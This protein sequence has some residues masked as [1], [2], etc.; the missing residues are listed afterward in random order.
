MNG[1][2]GAGTGGNNVNGSAKINAGPDELPPP[3]P[4]LTGVILESK[5]NS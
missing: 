4:S 1:Y 2:P 5:D 3:Y